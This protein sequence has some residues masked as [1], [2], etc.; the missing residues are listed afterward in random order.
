M[1]CQSSSAPQKICPARCST[2]TGGTI[3]R[4]TWRLV[5]EGAVVIAIERLHSEMKEARMVVAD[6]RREKPYFNIGT[7][8]I[9]AQEHGIYF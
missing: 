4:E 3:E 1:C 6:H 7:V 9:A 8:F 5:S 2:R